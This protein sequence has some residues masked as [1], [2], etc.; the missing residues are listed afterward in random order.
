MEKLNILYICH[1]SNL[2]GA[3]LS[4]YNMIHSMRDSVLPI[5]LLPQK[6]ESYELFTENNIRCIVHPFRMNIREKSII[7]HIVRFIPH[8]LRDKYF[9]LRCINSVI[10]DL[11]GMP[12]DIVHSNA[13][14]FTIGVDLAKKLSA[15]HVWHIRE[16]QDIDFGIK[17]FLGWKNLKNKIY[18]SDAVIAITKA[19]YEHWNLEKA[20]NAYSVWDAVESK[21]NIILNIPKKNFFFFCAAILNETKG[22]TFA[23]KSFAASGLYKK[24][25]KLVFAGIILDDYR[26][27]IN[28]LI[29][30][31]KLKDSIEFIGYCK[32]VKPYMANATA[33]LMCSKNE[34]LGRVT[35]EA[36]FYGCPVIAR[37]SGGT[38]ELIKNKETGF[39]FNDVNS[40]AEIMKK[41]IFCESENIN[42]IHN[43]QNFAKDNFSEE[44]YGQS[45]LNI[46][47]AINK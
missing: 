14:V 38:K 40:C 37:N 8:Y 31:Y 30:I 27:K 43:A 2:G 39:T 46:Y 45:I 5:V 19:V 4:L 7:K 23:I 12:I 35:I 28:K 21:N 47:S 26:R 17:P 9:N 44:K 22:V 29:N 16:F 32:D 10:S 1:T 3:A 42:I 13:S 15:K 36:M 20:S 24:G 34:G 25:Y 33:Y 18:S 6:G 11:N 41:M